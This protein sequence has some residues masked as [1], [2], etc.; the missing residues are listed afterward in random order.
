MARLDDIVNGGNLA[1]GLMVGAGV[2]IAWPLVGPIAR[3]L[4]KSLIKAGMI[5]YQQAE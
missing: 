3:P 4:A 1:T 2:L 5:A